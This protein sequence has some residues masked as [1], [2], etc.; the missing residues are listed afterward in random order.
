MKTRFAPSPSGNLHIG[1]A[2]TALFNLLLAR[3]NHGQFV[4]RFEDTD[5]SRSTTQSMNAI[6]NELRFLGI[7]WDEGPGVGDGSRYFQSQNLRKYRLMAHGLIASGLAYRC[8]C[9][10]DRIKV[11]KAQKRLQN[12]NPL[13]DGKCKHLGHEHAPGL[14]YSIR[15]KVTPKP[16][17]VNDLIKGKVKFHSKELEDFIIMRP[18]GHPMYNFACVVDDCSMGITHVI[19]GDE[20]LPNTP[21]QILI[22]E[23]LGLLPPEF[24]HIPVIVDPETGK[25]M[26]KRDEGVSIVDF[27][28]MGYSKE[29]LLMYISSLGCKMSRIKTFTID[30]F[31]EKFDIN[32]ISKKSACHS[33]RTLRKVSDKV[34]RRLVKLNENKLRS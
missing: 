8:Y 21:K 7:E 9:T 20:H 6:M 12:S 3:R 17:V 5:A 13:Y 1:G 29:E 25:K 33:V 27:I 22:Y 30:E 2:R 24:G 34:R 14:P 23:A 28:D 16:I 26:S 11:L 4:L 31:A 19:R 32:R 15:L 18:N 10:A